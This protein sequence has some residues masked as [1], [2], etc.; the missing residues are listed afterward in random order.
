MK[1]HIYSLHPSIW[2]DVELGMEIF[3][4]DDENYNPVEVEQ[5]VHCK[6]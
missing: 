1:S 5:I 4:S 6:S 3:D 2:D